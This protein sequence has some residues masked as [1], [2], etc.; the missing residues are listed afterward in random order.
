MGMLSTQ[1]S[2]INLHEVLF[3]DAA[4]INGQIVLGHDVR[5]SAQNGGVVM[6]THFI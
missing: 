6:A 5:V 2:A 4:A 1:F 3:R